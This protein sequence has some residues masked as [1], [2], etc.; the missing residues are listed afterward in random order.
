LLA[1]GSM[2]AVVLALGWMWWSSQLPD[3]YDLAEMGYADYGG[4]PVPPAMAGHGHGTAIADLVEARSGPPDREVTLT[5]RDDGD[6]ITVNGATPGPTPRSS[7]TAP[8]RSGDWL[9]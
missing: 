9:G 7:C 2:L 6:R 3:T 4:G 1:I 8:R 5:V